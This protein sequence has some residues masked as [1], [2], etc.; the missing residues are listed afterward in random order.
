MCP[1]LSRVSRS[2]KLSFTIAVCIST[3]CGSPAFAPIGTLGADT[4]GAPFCLATGGS[5]AISTVGIPASSIAL[6]KITAE[7]WQVPQPAVSIAASTFSAF[8]L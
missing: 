8:N 2:S 3:L 5:A 4:L 7:R 1:G 6:C